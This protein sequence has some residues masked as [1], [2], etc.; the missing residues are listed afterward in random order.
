MLTP[1]RVVVPEPDCVRETP[2]PASFAEIVAVFAPV[3]LKVYEVAVN[4]PVVLVIEPPLVPT[5]TLPTVWL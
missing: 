3:L 4:V 1:E 2:L 5:V